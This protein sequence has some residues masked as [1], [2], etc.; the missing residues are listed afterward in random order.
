[1]LFCSYCYIGILPFLFSLILRHPT[2]SRCY[3][4]YCILSLQLS[5]HFVTT[6]TFFLSHFVCCIIVFVF[7]LTLQLFPWLFLHHH[8]T[9]IIISHV[10]QL[11]AID[12]FLSFFACQFIFLCFYHI[13]CTCEVLSILCFAITSTQ[14]STM[15]FC[16]TLHKLLHVFLISCFLFLLFAF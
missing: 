9:Y 15:S 7:W 6:L 2:M 14:T 11:F 5:L 8:Y 16:F 4:H 1:M 3:P 13:I 10:S 12:Y